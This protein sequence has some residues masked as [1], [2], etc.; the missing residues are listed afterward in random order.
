[1]IHDK[2]VAGPYL[3]LRVGSLYLKTDVGQL[4]SLLL[5]TPSLMPSETVFGPMLP[6]RSG[7]AHPTYGRE[8]RSGLGCDGTPAGLQ[9][10][11]VV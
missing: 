7:P 8:P 2:L 4:S 1:M 5:K 6:P 9:A 3:W 10:R 11:E